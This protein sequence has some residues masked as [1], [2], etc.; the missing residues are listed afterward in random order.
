MINLSAWMPYIAVAAFAYIIFVFISESINPFRIKIDRSR[1]R[2]RL[3]RSIGM[4]VFLVSTIALVAKPYLGLTGL[5]IVIMTVALCLLLS[6]VPIYKYVRSF[7]QTTNV[8]STAKLQKS[9]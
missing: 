5:N 9:L 6:L 3:A 4:I 2:W 1:R 7:K 8:P